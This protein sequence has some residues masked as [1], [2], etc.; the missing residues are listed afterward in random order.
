VRRALEAGLLAPRFLVT[1]GDS[2]LPVDLRPLAAAH[3]SAGLP[4]TMTVLRN[5]GRWD[6]SNCVVAGG[7]VVRYEK[8]ADPAARPPEM[9]WIDYGVTAL[10]KEEVARWDDPAPFGLDRPLARLSGAGRLGAFAVTERF[11]E[12]G[13]PGGLAELEA[14]LGGARA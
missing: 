9:A 1:Y 7:L 8:I 5:E 10:E 11:Y 14:R 2:Y 13:S 6:A 12:I 3:L 4:A